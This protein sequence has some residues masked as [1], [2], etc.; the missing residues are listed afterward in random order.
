MDNFFPFNLYL[1]CRAQTES[2]FWTPFTVQRGVTVSRD[3]YVHC[4]VRTEVMGCNRNTLRRNPG[5]QNQKPGQLD[6]DS[7]RTP[8]TV[9]PPSLVGCKESELPDHP[10]LRPGCSTGHV[11]SPAGPSLHWAWAATAAAWLKTDTCLSIAG[12][13]Q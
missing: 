6:K 10:T 9:C 12:R 13:S 2:T 5:H 4:Y 8:L 7:I 3:S 1:L 11:W